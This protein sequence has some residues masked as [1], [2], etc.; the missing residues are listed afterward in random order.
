MPWTSGDAQSHTSKAN[1]PKKQRAWSA[2]A[3]S[4]LERTGNDAAAV[5]AAN[6]VIL[7]RFAFGGTVKPKM[8]AMLPKPYDVKSDIAHLEHVRPIGAAV[9]IGLDKAARA[10]A[11]I[12]NPLSTG[13]RGN[14]SILKRLKLSSFKLHK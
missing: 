7:K 2:V 9:G 8:P 13:L 3:N 12:A 1:T 10:E 14:P 4:V 11:N 5:R 6:G